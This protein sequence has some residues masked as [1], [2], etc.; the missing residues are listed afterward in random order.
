MDKKTNK[1]LIKAY[2][3]NNLKQYIKDNELEEFI[4][5]LAKNQLWLYDVYVNSIK[6]WDEQLKT[7]YT[8]H[9]QKEREMCNEALLY[10]GTNIKKQSYIKL[11]NEFDLPVCSFTEEEILWLY[12]KTKTNPLEANEFIALKQI[13]TKPL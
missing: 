2:E 8:P 10:I 4:K 7:V 5:F 1:F 9:Y 11:D 3:Q 6:Q 13:E 12:Y